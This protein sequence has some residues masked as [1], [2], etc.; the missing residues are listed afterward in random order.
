M[1]PGEKQFLKY[2]NQLR[3]LYDENDVG[4]F[5]GSGDFKFTGAFGIDDEG[6]MI[7]I[8]EALLKRSWK[9]A[10]ITLI[11]ETGHL[12]AQIYDIAEHSPYHTKM[13]EAIAWMMAEALFEDLKIPITRE[14]F[15]RSRR[16]A[17][18]S[19]GIKRLK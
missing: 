8:G 13:N 16:R 3:P 6:C 4:V 10:L 15:V 1:V 12:L 7:V 19:Y 17:L 2:A 14:H 9:Y 11:H 18:K 5:F